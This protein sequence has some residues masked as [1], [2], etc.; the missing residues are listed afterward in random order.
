MLNLN[1]C[2][3]ISMEGVSTMTKKGDTWNESESHRDSWTR[4]SVRRV[5][6]DGHYNQ[7]PTYHTGT[8]WT[9]DGQHFIFASGRRGMSAAFRCHAPTGDITQLTD[10][11]D[12]GTGGLCVSPTKGWVTYIAKNSLRAVHIETFQERTLIPDLGN[13]GVSSTTIDL[14]EEYVAMVANIIPPAFLSGERLTKP[15]VEYYSQPGGAKLRLLRTPLAGGEVEVIYEEDGIRS[16]HVQYNPSDPDLLLIDRDFPPRFWFSSDGKTNRIWSLR[17]STG[18]LIELPSRSGALFQV[19]SVWTWDGEAV[20]YHCPTPEGYVIGVDDREGNTLWEHQ[21]KEWNKYGHVSAMA[22]RPAFILDGNLSEDLLLWMYYDSELPRVE[23]IA[24]HGTNWG[25]HAGQHP[26]P[27]PQSDP[28]GQFISFNAAE[29][30]RSD[31]YVV[32]V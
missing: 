26:H 6:T 12:G 3:I 2:R 11:V 29:R 7:T 28:T 15:P 8:A 30:G 16:G 20:L 23:V 14:N 1:L 13:W 17:I 18:E 22:H 27:H 25:G 9:A 32:E 19:H 5:T 10:W 24:R 31:V 4:R 21:A